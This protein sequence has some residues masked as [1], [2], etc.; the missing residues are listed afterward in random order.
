MP[1]HMPD[2][3]G[4]PDKVRAKLNA[5]AD[6][7]RFSTTALRQ[8]RKENLDLNTPHQVFTLGLDVV[9]AGGGLDQAQPVGWRF[10]VV[11]GGQL[12]A[13]AETAEKP[14]GTHEVAQFT[15]GPFVAATDKALKIAHRLPQVAAASFEL[16]LLRVP[17]LYVM[18]LWLHS[19]LVDLLVPL[20]PS[21]IGKDGKPL[22]PAAFLNDLRELAGKMSPPESSA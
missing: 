16:R 14:D 5:F 7:G 13:S 12:I 19:P 6:S 1:V 11:D 3:Q 20:A 8:A 10:L 21:P 15:E 22:P 17:A 18:A 2:P 9:T 4:V